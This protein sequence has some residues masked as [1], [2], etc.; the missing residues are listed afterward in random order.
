MF[1]NV[2]KYKIFVTEE[3]APNLLV[4]NRPICEHDALKKLG[5]IVTDKRGVP[6]YYPWYSPKQWQSDSQTRGSGENIKICQPLLRRHSPQAAVWRQRPDLAA[7]LDP[8]L[9]F[10]F[11]IEKQVAAGRK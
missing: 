5:P 8:T 6:N 11:Q 7:V 4:Q 2:L 10:L 1:S 3:N 9:G